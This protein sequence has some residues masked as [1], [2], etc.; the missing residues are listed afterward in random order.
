MTRSLFV[1]LLLLPSLTAAADRVTVKGAV[2]EGKVKSVSAKAVVIETIYGKGDLTIATEDVTAIETETPFHVYKAD[3]GKVVGPV[4]AVTPA[5]ITVAAESG[6]TEVPFDAV[7][8]APRDAGSDANWFSRR[9]VESPWYSGFADLSFATFSGDTHTKALLAG[10]GVMRERGPDRTRFEASYR[11]ATSRDDE[12]DEGTGDV[13]EAD[14]QIDANEVRGLLRQE[15]DFTERWFL[16]GSVEAEH[17]SI[18]ELAY[19]L[20]PKVGTGYKIVNEED[21]Y[22]GADVGFAYVYENFQGPEHNDYMAL[23]LG[24]EHRWKLPLLKSLWYSRVDYLPSLTD[25]AEDYRVRGET[26]LLVPI[27]EQL[28]FKASVID[29]YNAQPAEDA[30]HN[31]LTTMLGISLIY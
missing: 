15:R 4:I 25:P 22:V 19:R 11:R 20:I 9:A 5:A 21:L 28:S 1:A 14:Q 16:F 18:E 12:D 3:D 2:L 6:A 23:A 29:E 30:V 7:Q 31:S 24:A 8:A 17:D 26:G 27:I 13:N 10:F